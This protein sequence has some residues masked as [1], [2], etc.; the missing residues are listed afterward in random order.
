MK[1]KTLTSKQI[2]NRFN[3]KIIKIKSKKKSLKI[4][5]KIKN[6]KFR[7]KN[8]NFLNLNLK[9]TRWLIKVNKLNKNKKI[10]INKDKNK[11]NKMN[12]LLM[13]NRTQDFMD[14]NLMT[15]IKTWKI[16]KINLMKKNIKSFKNN[17]EMLKL[18][19]KKSQKIKNPK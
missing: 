8:Y 6:K 19:N 18:K 7:I 2:K 13:V 10:M 1:K 14:N 17:L 15:K 16:I 9:M 3:K 5:I 12:N 11:A 4:Q